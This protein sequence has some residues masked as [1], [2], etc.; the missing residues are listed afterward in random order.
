[1]IAA[2][3][4]VAARYGW[5]IEVVDIDEDPTLEARWNELAPV[6]LVDGREICHHRLDAEAVSAFCETFPLESNALPD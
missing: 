4:P 3:S 2:L 1:M 5:R 6:L